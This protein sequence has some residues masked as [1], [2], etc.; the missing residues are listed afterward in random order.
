MVTHDPHSAKFASSI[1]FL[2][3]GELLPDGQVPEDWSINVAAR[4]NV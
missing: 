1:R 4:G 2:D 3:K